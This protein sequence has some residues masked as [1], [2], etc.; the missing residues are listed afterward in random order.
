M[1]SS[2]AP[3]GVS[4]SRRRHAPRTGVPFGVR[5]WFEVTLSSSATCRADPRE[6]Q[7]SKTIDRNMPTHTPSMP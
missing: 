2:C 6:H 4:S 3:A 7:D 5:A 1:S